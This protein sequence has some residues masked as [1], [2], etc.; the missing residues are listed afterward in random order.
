MKLPDSYGMDLL[1]TI[2]EKKSPISIIV[3]TGYFS[4][5]DAVTAMKLGASDYLCKPF[6]VDELVIAVEKAIAS[7]RLTEENLALRKQLYAMFDFSNIIGENPR[8][9]QVF[10]EVQKAANT[11]RKSVV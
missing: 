8:L 6:S 3:M 9:K 5:K 7:K 1:K 4:V 11:D 10:S 2:K